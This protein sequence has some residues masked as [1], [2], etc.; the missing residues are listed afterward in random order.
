MLDPMSGACERCGEPGC[1]ARLHP[2]GEASLTML[3]MAG[4]SVGATIIGLWLLPSWLRRQPRVTQPPGHPAHRHRQDR[5]MTLVLAALVG[6]T[7]SLTGLV[8][9]GLSHDAPPT[10]WRLSL[11]PTPPFASMEL[12]EVLADLEEGDDAERRRAA[13]EATLRRV[14]RAREDGL[15]PRLVVNGLV[16]V[17]QV[18]G[19]AALRLCGL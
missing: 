1:S 17:L 12:D 9:A 8:V 10:A 11:D 13:E 2:P 15:H 19:E 16:V 4:F 18:A 7:F 5:A 14:E 6:A 3:G